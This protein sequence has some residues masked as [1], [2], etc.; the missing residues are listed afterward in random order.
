MVICVTPI[1]LAVVLR[2]VDG[3]SDI[4]L[5]SFLKF[6]SVFAMYFLVFMASVLSCTEPAG[7]NFSHKL[8]KLSKIDN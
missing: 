1:R 4:S 5:V 7:R 3:F 6:F 8:E 2:H